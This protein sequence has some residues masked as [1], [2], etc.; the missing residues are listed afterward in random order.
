MV[1]SPSFSRSNV[2]LFSGCLLSVRN[3]LGSITRFDLASVK[4]LTIDRERN[5]HRCVVIGVFDDER[6]VIINESSS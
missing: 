3:I 5:G 4:D 2:N 6:A 1:K